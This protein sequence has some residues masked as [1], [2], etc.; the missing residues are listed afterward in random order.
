MTFFA[1]LLLLLLFSGHRHHLRL[2]RQRHFVSDPVELSAE[3]LDVPT[4]LATQFFRLFAALL[5]VVRL[6]PPNVN[7][8]QCRRNVVYKKF[9]YRRDLARV[10]D[11]YAAQG[12]LR[13]LIL[14]PIE[15]PCVTSY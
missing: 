2:R 9:N 15:S 4:Q 8:Y 7:Q 6:Q 12:H 14:A 10:R 3:R 1:L 11:H 5:E 13:S